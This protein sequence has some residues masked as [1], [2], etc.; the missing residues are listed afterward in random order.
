M[1]DGAE[2]AGAGGLLDGRRLPSPPWWGWSVVL[3][4]A[5]AA[6]ASH[7]T[8]QDQEVPTCPVI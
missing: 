4:T 6:S 1:G 2:L 8:D 5:P 3:G 7:P